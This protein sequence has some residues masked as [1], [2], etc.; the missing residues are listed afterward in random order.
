MVPGIL[1]CPARVNRNEGPIA[2][3]KARRTEAAARFTHLQA[4]V[5][6]ES[7]RALVAT[8][9][10]LH[11]LETA[12]A[13][14]SA[15]EKQLQSVQARLRVGEAD[16]LALLTAQLELASGQVARINALVEAQ[17]SLGLLEDALQRPLDASSPLPSVPEAHLRDAQGHTHT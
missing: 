13:L 3:A 7:A 2:E 17:T 5:I 9:A 6:G 11:T 8:L 4:R 1:H 15:Q 14:L 12:D 16:R 10:A